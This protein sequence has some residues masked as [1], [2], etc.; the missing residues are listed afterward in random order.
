[1][2]EPAKRLVDVAI[3]IHMET[4]DVHR[5]TAAYWV[6]SAMGRK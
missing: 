4:F 1:M 6:N 2:W 3:K 5:Q